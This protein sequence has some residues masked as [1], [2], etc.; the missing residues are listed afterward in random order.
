MPSW[1]LSAQVCDFR[2][3]KEVGQVLVPRN[4]LRYLLI[5]VFKVRKTSD[6]FCNFSTYICIYD[7]SDLLNSNTLSAQIRAYII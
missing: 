2:V 7:R 5:S 6:H 3:V 1:L 4:G